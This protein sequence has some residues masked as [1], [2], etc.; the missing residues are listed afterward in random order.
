MAMRLAIGIV[1]ILGAAACGSSEPPVGEGTASPA[2]VADMADV[3]PTAIRPFKI[4]VPDDV[5]ADLATRL[6][7]TRF[8]GRGGDRLDVWHRPGVLAGVADVLARELRLEGTGA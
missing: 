6:D 7:Q 1:M 3:D 4:D 2:A 8:P 5:L